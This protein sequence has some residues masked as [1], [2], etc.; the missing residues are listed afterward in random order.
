MSLISFIKVIEIKF[1]GCRTTM[2]LIKASFSQ[3][4][5]LFA[6]VIRSLLNPKKTH[7]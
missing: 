1:N 2:P 6:G 7:S 5:T 4:A 3:W